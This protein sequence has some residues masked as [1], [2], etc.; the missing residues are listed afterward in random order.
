MA[1]IEVS[2]ID[3]LVNILVTLLTGMVVFLTAL[4]TKHG[5]RLNKHDTDLALCAQQDRQHELE[6]RD[7]RKR[8][9][10]QR[11][12]ILE[13][14]KNNHDDVVQHINK[15]SHKIDIT[16]AALTA[17]ITNGKT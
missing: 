12:E 10:K 17:K 2:I 9:D 3:K 4:L 7:E 1:D 16:T 13:L 11:D 15:V 5:T 8:R 6:V 14:I